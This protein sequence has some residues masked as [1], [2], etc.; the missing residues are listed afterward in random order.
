MG[1]I[2]ETIGRMVVRSAI[3]RLGRPVGIGGGIALIALLVGGYVA[4]SRRVKEG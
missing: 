2:Y 4:A 1:W 3:S